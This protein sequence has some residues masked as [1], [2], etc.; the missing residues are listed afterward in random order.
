MY[1]RLRQ[2][3]LV[4]GKLEPVLAQLR[5]VLGLEVCFRDPGI[6]RHGLENALLPVGPVFIEVV[7][8][9][10]PNTTA[11]RY[12]ERRKGDGGYMFIVDCDNVSQRREQV[13]AM[14]VR[15][16]AENRKTGAAAVESFQLHP[17]DTG[18]AI[19]S[20]GTH[21]AGENL[22]GGY[23]WAGPDWQTFVRTEPVSAVLG[24]DI[25]SGDPTALARRWSD[26][27]KRQL[28]VEADGTPIMKLELGFARFVPDRDGRGEGLSSVHLKAT[29]KP[30]ILAAARAEGVQ[31][32]GDAVEICGT[33]FV[34]H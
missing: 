26:I 29:D 17:K 15:I 31:A 14:G 20:I 3:A 19:L 12:L 5:N 23:H 21:A 22:M 8:P 16:V 34:L 24:A 13:K 30:R 25:Q 7:A 11:E 9:V 33:R 2:I 10:Q 32:S 4:A 6:A 1:V 28:A 27:F 18:G